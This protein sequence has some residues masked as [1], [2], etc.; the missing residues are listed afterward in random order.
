MT[1]ETIIDLFPAHRVTEA[2]D[3][4]AK[5]AAKT[6]RAAAKAGATPLTPPTLT[7]RDER[8]VVKCYTCRHIFTEAALGGR[9]WNFCP[10][11]ESGK[12]A[13]FRVCTLVLEAVKP[14]LAG[15]EFLAVIEPLTAGNLIRKVPGADTTDFSFDAWRTGDIVC[16]HCKTTRRR[17]ETFLVRATGEDPAIP[18]GT[19]REVGRNCL[20]AFLGGKSAAEIVSGLGFEKAIR[21]LGEDEEGSGG[22]R[23]ADPLWVPVEFLAWTCSV[24]RSNGWVSRAAARD[25]VEKRATADV[26]GYLLTPPWSAEGRD[27]WEK[28]CREYAPTADDGEKAAGVLA[29]AR[30]LNPS[31]DYETNLHLVAKEEWLNPKH[32]GILASAVVAYERARG[33]EIKRAERAVRAAASG[34]V[35]TVGARE[36]FTDLTV[37]NVF[38]VETQYGNLHINKFRDAAGNALVWKTASTRFTPGDKI[39]LTGTVKAHAEYKGEKQTELTRCAE[40]PAKVK[41]AKKKKS[42]APADRPPVV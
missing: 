22:G 30:A 11:C 31:G 5:F 25:H 27:E 19:V 6:A 24:V 7:V 8:V 21:D 26:V 4:L 12:I 17:L 40:G 28:A 16:D 32:S 9:S 33:N 35:G 13:P 38:T 14:A 34:H 41:A 20:A 37:D 3:L 10:D 15:W 42:K 36:T 29:W 39:V 23:G 18:A 1:T 2:R